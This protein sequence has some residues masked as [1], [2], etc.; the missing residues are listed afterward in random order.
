MERFCNFSFYSWKA[1]CEMA[2][3]V[4]TRHFFFQIS[5]IKKLLSSS[6]SEGQKQPEACNFI[7]KE[8]LA[9]VFSCEI[10]EI[11]KNTFFTEHLCGTTSGRRRQRVI[12]DVSQ[13]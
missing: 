10:C 12:G 3:T 1:Y 7:K 11:S 13:V 5:A 6:E 8:T 9:H 2:F 4:T